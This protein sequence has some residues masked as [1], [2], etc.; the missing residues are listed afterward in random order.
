MS[1]AGF[2]ARRHI[3]YE[4]AGHDV[5]RT[6]SRRTVFLCRMAAAGVGHGSDI[7]APRSYA[8]DLRQTS[9]S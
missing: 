3:P 1:G 6:S 4:A 9:S 5:I 8:G 7:A 2:C